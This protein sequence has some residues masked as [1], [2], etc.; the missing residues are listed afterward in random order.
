MDTFKVSISRI[1]SGFYQSFKSSLHQGTYTTAKN[2]L[3]SKKVCFCFYTEGCFQKTCSCSADC[4]SISQC[5]FFCFSC[6]ILFYSYQT[7]SSLASLIFTSYGMTWSLWCNHG[8]IH[9]FWWFNTSKVDVEAMGKHQHI[10]FFQVWF[11]GFFVKLCLFFI[12]DQDHDDI[13]FFSSLCCG[14]YLK[15]LCFCFC[16]GFASFI[17]TD[18]NITSGISQVQSMCMSLAAVADDGNGLSF[19]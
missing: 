17:Q 12:V 2:C 7:R 10:S 13:C 4:K 8:N 14:I 18:D 15:S 11:D 19:Q 9:I 6:S 1:I 5:Q 3:F 16:P